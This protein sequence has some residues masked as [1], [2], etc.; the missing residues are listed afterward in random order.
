M[1]QVLQVFYITTGKQHEHAYW[2]KQIK[3]VT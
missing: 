2:V 1:L 3:L